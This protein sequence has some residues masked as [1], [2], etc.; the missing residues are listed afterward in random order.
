MVKGG[1]W[2]WDGWITISA[3]KNHA[4]G[5]ALPHPPSKFVTIHYLCEGIISASGY[6]GSCL[7]GEGSKGL[8][9]VAATS[10]SRQY[11][12]KF[13]RGD[14]RIEVAGT[15]IVLLVAENRRQAGNPAV[16]WVAAL[17]PQAAFF[18]FFSAVTGAWVI[19]PKLAASPDHRLDLPRGFLKE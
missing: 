2:K 12:P 7:Q 9:F 1:A 6:Y 8:E 5:H 16:S 15:I 13:R 11:S 17:L 14:R 18:V 19:S 10:K 3:A 4:S